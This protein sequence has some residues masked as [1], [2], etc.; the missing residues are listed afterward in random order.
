MSNPLSPIL[1]HLPSAS[2]HTDSKNA[3]HAYNYLPETRYAIWNLNN[4]DNRM[5]LSVIVH[6]LLNTL[7]YL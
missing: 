5:C 1:R 3:T 7:W 2:L 6:L 4:V